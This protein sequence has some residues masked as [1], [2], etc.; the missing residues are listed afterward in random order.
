MGHVHVSTSFNY[1]MSL[2]GKQ[3]LCYDFSGLTRTIIVCVC[4]WIFIGQWN[5]DMAGLTQVSTPHLL[6]LGTERPTSTLELKWLEFMS[7]LIK[8]V[9]LQKIHA[10]SILNCLII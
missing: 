3:T 10:L 2:Q 6:S 1:D 8:L 5:R 9:I 7:S 4:V